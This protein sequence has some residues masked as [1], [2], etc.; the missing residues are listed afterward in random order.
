ME[1]SLL[2]VGKIEEIKNKRITILA[3][4][5]KRKKILEEVGFCIDEEGFVIDRATGEKVIAEE[6]KEINIRKDESFGIIGSSLKFVKNI[7]G[8]SKLLTEKGI[9]KVESEK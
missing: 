3:T 5:S 8:Y 2:K 1:K 6:G 7:V 4:L 9:I